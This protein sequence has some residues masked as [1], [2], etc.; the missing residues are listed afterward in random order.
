MHPRIPIAFTLA[1]ILLA[2]EDQPAG[3]APEG[4][5]AAHA[6]ATISASTA[7]Q[8]AQLRRLVAPFHD[9]QTAS[10]A[11][12]SAPITPCLV[13]GDL[14]STP[15]SGAMGFH[16]GNLGYIQDGGVVDLLQPELLLYEPEQNGKL[17][18]VGVEYIVPFT[19]HP[20]TAPAPTL[21]GHEFAQVPEFGVWGLHIYVGRHNPS[22]TFAPWNPKVSCDLGA[23]HH[24]Q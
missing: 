2:C 24:G 20:A 16:F 18:F 7:S 4:G 8:I 23:H 1:A 10:D 3:L 22:G 19:D 17:R 14:P 15:G 12:W 6:P 21:L 13:A 9:F 5:A 11:G